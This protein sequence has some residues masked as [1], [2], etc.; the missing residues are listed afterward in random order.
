MFKYFLGY[1]N[2]IVQLMILLILYLLLNQTIQ[3]LND[4]SDKIPD[5][6][7]DQ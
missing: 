1:L 6:E 3:Y 2:M 5:Q 7:Q 4:T